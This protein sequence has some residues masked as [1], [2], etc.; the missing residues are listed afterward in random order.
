MP[1]ERSEIRF[2][3]TVTHS[4]AVAGW[5]MHDSITAI[6]ELNKRIKKGLKE[7]EKRG[8][9]ERDWEKREKEVEAEK[10]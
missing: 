1:I 4:L 8:R 5:W 10:D 7:L 2:R 6:F 3:L 9:D